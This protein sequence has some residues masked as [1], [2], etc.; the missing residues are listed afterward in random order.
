MKRGYL[1]EIAH[2]ALINPDKG[3]AYQ[4]LKSVNLKLL[5]REIISRSEIDGIDL[6][7]ICNTLENWNNQKRICSY[8]NC[9]RIKRIGMIKIGSFIQT[10]KV[11]DSINIQLKN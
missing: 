2:R 8:E 11:Q 3:L 5:E 7:T 6:E 4:V 10:P 1:V 9:A